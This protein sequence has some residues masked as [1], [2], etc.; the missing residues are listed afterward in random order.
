MDSQTTTA[1]LGL[2]ER[3]KGVLYSPAFKIRHRQKATDFT[4]HRCLPF[5]L[6]VLFLL[7]LLK[8]AAQDEFFKMLN[9]DDIAIR[10]VTKSAFSQAR[11]KP[12]CSR[13]CRETGG[14]RIKAVSE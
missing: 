12:Y 1:C 8:R 3:L 10:I 11:Q 9:G 2:F 13:R 4:R 5:I 7:N 6:V 14:G